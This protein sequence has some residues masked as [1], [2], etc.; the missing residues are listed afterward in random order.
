DIDS[1]TE[2]R[3]IPVG[4]AVHTDW[5][6][7]GVNHSIGI[8]A[9]AHMHF[10]RSTVN[11]VKVRCVSSRVADERPAGHVENDRRSTGQRLAGKLND[12]RSRIDDE[13]SSACQHKL[14]EGIG[15]ATQ[16]YHFIIDGDVPV[17]TRGE[18]HWSS[19]PAGRAAAGK[20]AWASPTRVAALNGVTCR[21]R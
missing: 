21:R 15:S 8:G 11:D 17:Q 20:R 7:G 1:V 6:I 4:T 13:L 19:G 12:H 5:R 18:K 9:A 10:R 2:D 14:V 16:M 3:T